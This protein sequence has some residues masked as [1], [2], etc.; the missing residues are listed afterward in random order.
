MILD[1]CWMTVCMT[2]ALLVSSSHCQAQVK[3]YDNPA[4]EWNKRISLPKKKSGISPSRK[5]VLPLV[6]Q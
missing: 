6:I 1:D 5:V 2:G 4:K 3:Q